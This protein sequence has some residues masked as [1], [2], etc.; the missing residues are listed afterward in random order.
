[1][2]E[3][4][5][6]WGGWMTALGLLAVL[7]IFGSA[8]YAVNSIKKGNRSFRFWQKRHPQEDLPPRDKSYPG[9]RDD[10]R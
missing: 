10:L 4:A 7:L 1:M 3:N 5:E 2:I 6:T 8:L 9:P